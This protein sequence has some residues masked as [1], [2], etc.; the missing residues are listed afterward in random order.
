MT[1]SGECMPKA[2]IFDFGNV[3]CHFDNA[4]FLQRLTSYTDKSY[5]ELENLIYRS[6]DVVSRYEMG[7]VTSDAF[8]DHATRT[9]L[10]SISR[11]EFV[12]AF[13][14]IFADNHQ[15]IDLVR[16][17]GTKYR[18]G[19][20]SNTNEL[21]Y[22]QAIVRCPVFDLFDS[23]TTSFQV[24]ALKPSKAIYEDALRQLQLPAAECIY[25]DDISS[26]V[27]AAI[28]MG[29]KGIQYTSYE[30]LVSSLTGFGVH[31]QQMKAQAP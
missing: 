17:L 23:V 16:M 24:G 28:G 31:V 2:V 21:D 8:I 7:L 4:L 18:L 1:Q 14:G 11:N 5:D 29:M 12:N 25:V 9:C 3:I 13:T 22:Q 6:S 26:Y 10:L 27:D 19:L 15:V 20:L 30:R